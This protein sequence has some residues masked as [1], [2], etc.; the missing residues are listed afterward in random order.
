MTDSGRRR[1]RNR[2]R[3]LPTRRRGYAVKRDDTTTGVVPSDP[4]L[5][6]SMVC[7][8]GETFTWQGERHCTR[9][10]ASDMTQGDSDV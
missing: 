6:T 3:V 10:I 7:L 1:R 2:W 8:C 4:P 5:G 9:V